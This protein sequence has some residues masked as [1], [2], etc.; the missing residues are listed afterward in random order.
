MGNI[1]DF[2]SATHPE[3]QDVQNDFTALLFGALQ[4]EG[5]H[6]MT[7]SVT[8]GHYDAQRSVPG[9]GVRR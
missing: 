6:R 5:V 1:Q 7:H 9:L 2:F 3:L 8:N 4:I